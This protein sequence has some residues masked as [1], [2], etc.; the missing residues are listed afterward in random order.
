MRLRIVVEREGQDRERERGTIGA[1]S[2]AAALPPLLL[3]LPT[4]PTAQTSSGKYTVNLARSSS[5]I[6]PLLCSLRRRLRVKLTEVV[7]PVSGWSNSSR[8]N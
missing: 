7:I 2:S 1:P 6:K 8:C 5:S 4:S 3:L